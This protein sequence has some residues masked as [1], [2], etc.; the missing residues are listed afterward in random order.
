M[1]FHYLISTYFNNNKK[2]MLQTWE[3][4]FSIH[5]FHKITPLPGGSECRE[6]ACNAGDPGSIPELGRFPWWKK[7]LLTPEFLPGEFHGQRR[8]ADY[9]PWRRKESDTTEQLSNYYDKIHM[10]FVVAGM[11][12]FRSSFFR[13]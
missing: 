13:F 10:L 2:K 12:K 3:A 5:V 11:G 9:N 4:S 8:L 1:L 6:S 7:W